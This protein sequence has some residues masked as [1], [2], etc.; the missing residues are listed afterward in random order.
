M[1]ATSVGR[2][3]GLAVVAIAALG[4]GGCAQMGGVLSSVGSAFDSSSSPAAFQ[5]PQS[6]GATRQQSL[7]A[8]PRLGTIREARWNN[9]PH[10]V[11]L[12]GGQGSTRRFV[13]QRVDLQPMWSNDRS[14]DKAIELVNTAFAADT[15][16][17]AALT[18]TDTT[19]DRVGVWIIDVS[20]GGAP[21][22]VTITQ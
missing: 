2:A 5:G 1:A 10:N 7:N 19:F 6:G 12:R 15:C 8:G 14:R 16:G 11:A 20:C 21:A 4:L 9:V 22:Q 13:I 17:G 3:R 18:V